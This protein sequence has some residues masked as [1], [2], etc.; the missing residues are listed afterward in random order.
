MTPETS[1]TLMTFPIS[2]VH[3]SCGFGLDL[4]RFFATKTAF[5]VAVPGYV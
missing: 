5:C 2:Q 3:A 4:W 1:M